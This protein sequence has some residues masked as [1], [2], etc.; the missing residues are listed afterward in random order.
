MNDEDAL[1]LVRGAFAPFYTG[2]SMSELR[3]IVFQVVDADG[4]GVMAR[5]VIAEQV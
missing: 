3:S 1:V 2:A 5:S 4:N